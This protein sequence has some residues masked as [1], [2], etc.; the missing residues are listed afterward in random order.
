MMY[1]RLEPSGRLR[2]GG[3]S[4]RLFQPKDVF[5]SKEHRLVLEEWRAPIPRRVELVT[6]EM[7]QCYPR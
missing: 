7:Y 4:W 1:E 6:G 2:D 5:R 3:N